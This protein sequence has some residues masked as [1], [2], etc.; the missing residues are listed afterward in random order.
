VKWS[1]TL[2][3]EGIAFGSAIRRPFPLLSFLNPLNTPLKTAFDAFEWFPDKKESGEGWSE[4][5]LDGESRS[6][7]KKRAFEH[8][9]A[10]SVHGSWQ[11]NPL[12]PEN[13]GILLD[14]ARFAH[15]IGA[16]LLVTHLYLGEGVESYVH[17][18]APL[19][20][21]LREKGIRLAIENTPL[22]PPESLNDLFALLRASGGEEGVGMCLDLGHANLCEATRNDYLLYMDRLDSRVPIIHIHLHENEGDSDSHL[23]LFTG[24]AG[25]DPSGIQGF[26]Q[27]IEKKGVFREHHPGAMAAPPRTAQDGTDTAYP[28]PWRNPRG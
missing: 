10:L 21:G 8:D 20:E 17:A 14:Q 16:S 2:R 24:P 28:P 19:M 4:S 1:W 9:I 18:L 12:V 7:I 23:P 5:D 13:R 25:K 26:I 15:D 22:T 3:K 27:R 6:S 11:A